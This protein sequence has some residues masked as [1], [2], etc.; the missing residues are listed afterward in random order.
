LWNGIV[1][2]LKFNRLGLER[3]WHRDLTSLEH[4]LVF[5]Q[6][7]VNFCLCMGWQIRADVD[8][9]DVMD[10]GRRSLA[11][12]CLSPGSES[13]LPNVAHQRLPLLPTVVVHVHAQRVQAGNTEEGVALSRKLRGGSDQRGKAKDL[14]FVEDLE[15]AFLGKR[16]QAG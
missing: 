4:A 12:I 2:E 1:D 11:L 9:A 14:A 15:R 6:E 16:S 7:G 13:L 10:N 3:F 8:L 5:V